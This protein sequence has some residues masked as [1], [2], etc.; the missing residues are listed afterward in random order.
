MASD[1]QRP[2]RAM[3]SE[4][5]PAHRRAVA[6]PGRRDRAERREPGI[7]VT[8]SRRLAECLSARVMW[9]DLTEAH[10]V[11]VLCL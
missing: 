10:L 2:R 9:R 6:P 4:S 5:I 1:F 7:P 3:E 8:G 11:G